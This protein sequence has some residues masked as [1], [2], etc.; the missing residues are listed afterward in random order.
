MPIEILSISYE[1]SG[2]VMSSRNRYLQSEEQVQAQSLSTSL[3]CTLFFQKFL[4]KSF[5]IPTTNAQCQK[6]T[7]YQ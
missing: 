7:T 6:L 3:F 4:S 2:L 5:Q 1:K